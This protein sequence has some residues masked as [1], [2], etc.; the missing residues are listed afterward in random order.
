MMR[1]LTKLGTEERRKEVEGR[2][3]QKAGGEGWERKGLKGMA[4][5]IEPMN[6]EWP[7]S[8]LFLYLAGWGGVGGIAWYIR[9]K[10]EEEKMLK[11]D[12]FGG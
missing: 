8:P 5:G 4:D 2:V 1:V 7:L 11:N 10:G 6:Q 3:L 12:H 9:W